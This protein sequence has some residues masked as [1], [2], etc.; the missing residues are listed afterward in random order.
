MLFCYLQEGRRRGMNLNRSD[1]PCQNYIPPDWE[2]ESPYG[3]QPHQCPECG[4]I[5][6]FCGNCNTDHH[7]GGWWGCYEHRYNKEREKI[8]KLKESIPF[9]ALSAT[10]AA[11][12]AYHLEQGEDNGGLS[13]GALAKFLSSWAKELRNFDS[14]LKGEL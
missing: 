1:Q 3:P 10:N 2:Q 14:T 8:N 6:Y 13:R 12:I 5:R 11:A 7:E 4:G 9:P